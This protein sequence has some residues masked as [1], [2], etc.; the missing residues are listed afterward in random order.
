MSSIGMEGRRPRDIRASAHAHIMTA[1]HPGLRSEK[2]T[3]LMPKS[4]VEDLRALR[5]VTGQSTGDLVNQLL[6]A[7]LEKAQ[8]DVEA[9]RAM[10]QIKARAQRKG[11]EAS[12]VGGSSPAPGGASEGRASEGVSSEPSGAMPD[13]AFIGSWAK[14]QNKPAKCER[15]AKDY[16]A[17][18]EAGG[19]PFIGSSELF[20]SEVLAA[21]YSSESVKT[22]GRF[23]NRFIEAWQGR[24][25]APRAVVV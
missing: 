14:L 19:H 8:A 9:G 18:C 1:L 16:V 21:K 3:I 24:E 25:R 5:L 10:L 17:W 2:I 6:E 23:V 12:N 13:A 11:G 22:Y 15:I 20:T 7:H 4:L